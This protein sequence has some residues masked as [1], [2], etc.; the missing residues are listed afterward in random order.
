M[1]TRMVERETTSTQT[2]SAHTNLLA[3]FTFDVRS[4]PIRL[5]IIVNDTFKHTETF[6]PGNGKKG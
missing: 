4:T 2:H 1:L 6:G 5:E 3:I